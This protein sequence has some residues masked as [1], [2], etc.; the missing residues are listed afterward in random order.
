MISCLMRTKFNFDLVSF[1]QTGFHTSL[2]SFGID[3]LVHIH[4]H[5]VVVV[6]IVVLIVDGVDDRH[7][8]EGGRYE[9]AKEGE[10]DKGTTMSRVVTIP[11]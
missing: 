8:E 2:S 1:M 6:V 11:A 4:I 9:E 7:G 5:I 3:I 10:D